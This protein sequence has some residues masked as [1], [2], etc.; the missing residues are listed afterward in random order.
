MIDYGRLSTPPPRWDNVLFWVFR[1]ALGC[2]LRLYFRFQVE[3]APPRSGG[4]VLAAN[5]ASFLDPLVLGCSVRRRV[6]YLMT[7]TV[8]RSARAGWFF[9][10]NRTIPLSARGGN[11]DALRAA[12]AV[13]KQQR[14]VGIFPEG[15]VSRDG[16]LMLGSPGAV[17]LVLNEG[18]PIVPVGILGAADALGPAA[19]W[20][21][22]KKITVR[23]GEPILPEEL[24]A[25]GG[26]RRERLQRATR[27][28]MQRIAALTGQ[29]AREDVLDAVESTG[30]A[31]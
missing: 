22:P 24:D 27:L 2:F 8:W 17:S 1:A 26:D 10:W 19:A 13:L 18:L 28:I 4:Y 12:R 15:G 16:K 5:H 25:L 21:R 11:R 30:E 23:Y 7:E 31:N 6:I 20:P 14:V 3:G 29:E 9:R